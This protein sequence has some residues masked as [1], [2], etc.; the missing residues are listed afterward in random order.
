MGIVGQARQMKREGK[1][2]KAFEFAFLFGNWVIFHPS[3]PALFLHPG[4]P[5][6]S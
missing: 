1:D 2:Q 3:H 5:Q 6:I 4:I